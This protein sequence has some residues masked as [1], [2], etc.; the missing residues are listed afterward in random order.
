LEEEAK[1]YGED[2]LFEKLKTIDP[3]SAL[4]I[5]KQNVKRVIRALEYFEL[6]GEKISVHNA[7][8][9]E[10]ESPYDFR[11]YVLTMDREKLYERI[12]RRVDFM[13]EQGL[14]SEVMQLKKDGCTK[15]MTSMQGLGYKQLLDYLDGE[16]TL[17]AAIDRIKQETRHFAKRQLTWFRREKDVTY[18]DVEKENLLDVYETRHF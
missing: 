14:L 7:S 13:M 4:A 11:F 3:E 5:P 12:D 18:V 8:E 6:T 9:R 1:I 17:E 10:K 2:A 15:E 16:C